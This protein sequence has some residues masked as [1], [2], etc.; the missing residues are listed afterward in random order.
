MVLWNTRYQ[1]AALNH[2]RE[3]G[4]EVHG[5]DVERLSPLRHEHVNMLG[6]Y[7]F[8]LY[9][10]VADGELRPLGTPPRRAN[11]RCENGPDLSGQPP[12]SYN[13][14]R[15]IAGGLSCRTG[16]RE[17]VVGGRTPEGHQASSSASY[18]SS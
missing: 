11:W 10:R 1:Q 8:D 14:V 2:L 15:L 9:G 4:E 16:F 7:H 18:A 13:L 5:E 17:N 12:P 6:R 3:Q